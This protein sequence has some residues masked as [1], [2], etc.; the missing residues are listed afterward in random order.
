LLTV[1]EEEKTSYS[2]GGTYRNLMNALPFQID[3]NLGATAG[4]AE[5]LLQSHTDVIHLLPAIPAAW[6][7]GSVKGLK[8]RGGFVVDIEWKAGKIIA[9]SIFS[10]L[11]ETCRVRA[12]ANVARVSSV[13]GPVKFKQAEKDIVEFA[14]QAGETYSVVMAPSTNSPGVPGLPQR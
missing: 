7:D 3:G 2:D 12:S 1:V 13:H 6:A 11:T 9:A 10:R 14:T 5:M 4:I 8:A